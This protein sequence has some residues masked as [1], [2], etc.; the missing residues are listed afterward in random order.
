MRGFR[1]GLFLIAALAAFVAVNPSAAKAGAPTDSLKTTSSFRDYTVRIY[2]GTD[3]E[4]LKILKRGRIVHEMTGRRL[5]IGY[6]YG[7]EE[8]SKLIAM[9]SDITGR[10]VPNLVVSEY[11]GGA[12]CCLSFHIFE[13]GKE[14][15]KIGVLDA[16]HSDLAHFEERSGEKGLVF[17]ANDWAFAYW[18]ASFAQSPAPEVILRF[19][20]GRY[21][22]AVDLMRKPAPPYETVEEQIRQVHAD[23][24]WKEDGRPPVKLWEFMLYLIYTGNAT[25]AWQFFEKA[26][27]PGVPGKTEFLAEFRSQ[28]N[29]SQYW[30]D[31]G[32]K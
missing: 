9:G 20:D 6:M 32:S 11:T 31:L 27:V 23:K 25:A 16:K 7:D 12:H 1:N 30:Q 10:G 28:L 19:S 29:K 26:W 24:A 3:D 2:Q 15:R 22:L 5:Y 14:F 17:V 18:N 21:R 4:H 13:I 8:S